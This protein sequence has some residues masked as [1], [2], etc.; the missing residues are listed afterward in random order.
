[1]SEK[2][3]LFK[4]PGAE[5]VTFYGYDGFAVSV[6]CSL[7]GVMPISHPAPPNG[8]LGL[9]WDCPAGFAS[10]VCATGSS[11]V[12]LAEAPEGVASSLT[13]ENV[14]DLV[15]ASLGLLVLAFAFRQVRRFLNR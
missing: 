15:S 12:A 9:T 1:M 3:A 14:G 5:S 11:W 8:V 7:D 4:C 2:A 10:N 6:W 13:V